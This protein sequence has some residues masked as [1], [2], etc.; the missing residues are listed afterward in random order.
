MTNAGDNHS[1]G[2]VRSFAVPFCQAFSTQFYN[3]TRDHDTYRHRKTVPLSVV[4]FCVHR[5]LS[6]RTFSWTVAEVSA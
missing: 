3:N 1:Y 4:D 2:T 6:R 5:V